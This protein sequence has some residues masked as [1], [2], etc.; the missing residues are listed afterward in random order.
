MPTS[1]ARLQ[2]PVISD[3]IAHWVGKMLRT[4]YTLCNFRGGTH[5][6]ISTS[7]CNQSLLFSWKHSNSYVFL[8]KSDRLT[9]LRHVCTDKFR[10]NKHIVEIF[11]LTTI[12]Q[13]R[14]EKKKKKTI[15]CLQHRNIF[16]IYTFLLFVHPFSYTSLHFVST[17]CYHKSTFVISWHAGRILKGSR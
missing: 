9:T 11:N 12:K 10:R 15:L 2:S 16:N 17:P 3:E 5:F 7:P 6:S 4:I 14:K 13:K 8:R 1:H